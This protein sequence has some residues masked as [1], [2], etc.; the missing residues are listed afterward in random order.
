MKNKINEMQNNLESLR[1]GADVLQER[2]SDLEDKHIEILQL[3]DTELRF[4]KNE[5]ILQEI[6][7][8]IRKS[9]IRI[10]GIQ[11]GEERDKGREGLFKEII[12]ENSPNLGKELGHTST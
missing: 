5:E 9:N 12:A 10:I 11:E 6:S 3:Q 7:N 2:I 1:N 8:S 4:L